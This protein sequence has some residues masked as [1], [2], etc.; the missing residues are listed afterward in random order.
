MMRFQVMAPNS[1][2][3]SIESATPPAGATR[4]PT[5][6]AT[7]MQKLSR[8]DSANKVENAEKATATRAAWP[9]SLPPSQ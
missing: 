3:T 9:A 2:A 1:T 4:L 8:H 5:V 7:S 6:F